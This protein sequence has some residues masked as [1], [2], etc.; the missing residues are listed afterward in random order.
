MTLCDE[1]AIGEKL[2]QCCG[3]L[4]MTGEKKTLR[5]G[6]GAGLPA[7]PH[8]SGGGL[9]SIYPERPPGCREFFCE[10]FMTGEKAAYLADGGVSLPGR[11]RG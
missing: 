6:D 8:L 4:P 1:C 10:A 5:E 2:M 7:C 9:C 11:F 3:R